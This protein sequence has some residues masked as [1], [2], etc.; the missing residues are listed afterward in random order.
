MSLA[1]SCAEASPGPGSGRVGLVSV[2]VSLP[3]YLG[4]H[5]G[6]PVTSGIAK[7]P[8]TTD[9]LWLDHLNLEGDGQADPSQHGGEDKAVYAYPYEHL[10]PWG[11]ELGQELGPAAFGENLTTTG[12]TEDDVRI[13]DHWAWGDAVL[14]VCQPRWPCYKLAMYRS[15]GDIQRRMH[16]NG[17]TGWYLRVLQA[18]RVPVAGPVTVVERHPALA[19]VRLAHDAASPNS[20]VPLEVIEALLV[21]PPLSDEWRMA[22][23]HRLP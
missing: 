7:V 6:R 21:L 1:G 14:E 15:K 2:N 20:G 23:A 5:R 12:W 11:A 8:V 18:G 22:L 16:A 13:G 10:A 19:S 17:R 4:Q 3:K 9:E